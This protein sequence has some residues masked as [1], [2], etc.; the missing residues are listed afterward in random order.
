[1]SCESH[2]QSTTSGV[3]RCGQPRVAICRYPRAARDDATDA[4]GALYIPSALGAL[5]LI[6]PSLLVALVFHP[7]L[8]NNYI[9]DTAWAFALY[10]EAVCIL[11]QLT[12]FQRAKD[13]EV[14]M[15]TGNFVFGVALSRLLYFVFWLSSYHELN[16]KYAEA[17]HQRY[18]GL[19]V[20]I[21]QV[22]QHVLTSK[23]ANISHHV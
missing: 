2:K 6:V 7:S 13:K 15:Y 18:P 14:E 21:F 17:F 1:M 20:V 9:T 23:A 11:P 19:L 22:W 3:H 5:W 12:M 10:L 4:F 16:N 8:N